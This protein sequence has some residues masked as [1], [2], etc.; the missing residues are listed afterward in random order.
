M[1]PVFIAFDVDFKCADNDTDALVWRVDDDS[2]SSFD[3]TCVEGCK[4]YVYKDTPASIVSDWDLACGFN[5][6]LGT[7]SNSGIL[8]LIPF[9]CFCDCCKAMLVFRFLKRKIIS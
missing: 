3:S 8:F 9:F 7:F 2:D 6:V 1:T 4:K 5:K